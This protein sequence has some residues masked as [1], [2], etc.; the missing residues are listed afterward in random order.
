MLPIQL[1]SFWLFRPGLQK[2]VE[3][4]KIKTKSVKV[5]QPVSAYA[6]FNGRLLKTVWRYILVYNVD[7]TYCILPPSYCNEMLFTRANVK[8][9]ALKYKW[10]ENKCSGLWKKLIVSS[11]AACVSVTSDHNPSD[12][13]WESSVLSLPR[14]FNEFKI[15][16]KMSHWF[17]CL[18]V[19]CTRVK[20]LKTNPFFTEYIDTT[21]LM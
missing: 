13:Y 10:Q 19:I 21:L 15:Q 17:S 8:S 12:V 3:T 9:F 20:W 4:K 7:Q 1:H 18:V 11:S 2:K 6:F 16:I 14:I 5:A